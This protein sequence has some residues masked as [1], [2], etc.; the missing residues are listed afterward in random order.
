[1][2]GGKLGPRLQKMVPH[3]QQKSAS[4]VLRL[5]LNETANQRLYH[6]RCASSSPGANE[7]KLQCGSTDSSVIEMW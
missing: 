7:H 3:Q 4:A 1:M 2:R 5:D 6:V